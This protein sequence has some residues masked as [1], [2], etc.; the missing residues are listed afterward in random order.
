MTTARSFHICLPI[1]K[2][3]LISAPYISTDISENC[4]PVGHAERMDDEAEQEAQDGGNGGT[5][6]AHI[7]DVAV[8]GARFKCSSCSV[9]WICNSL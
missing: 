7:C 2:Q 4:V 3:R 8:E 9:S 1:K 6:N 5:L